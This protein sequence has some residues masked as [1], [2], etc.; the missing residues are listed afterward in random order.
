[1]PVKAHNLI[2]MVKRYYSPLCCIYCIITIELLDIGKDIALQIAFKAIN[3]STSFNSFIFTL[4]VFRAYLRIIK[5]NTPN[6]TVIQQAAALKKA[7]EEV[8]K[9]KAE[10]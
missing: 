9:L 5:S 8:K 10:R 6:L 2:G 7:I 1:V 3:N 4:L